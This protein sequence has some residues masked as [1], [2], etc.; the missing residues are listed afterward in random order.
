MKCAT[1]CG[2][3][4]HGALSLDELASRPTCSVDQ[5]AAALGIARSTAFAAA[6]DGSLPT[7]RLS[8]RLLVPTAKLLVLLGVEPAPSDA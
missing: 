8:H 6:H 5:A 4:G 1:C 7:I 3:Q 2:A